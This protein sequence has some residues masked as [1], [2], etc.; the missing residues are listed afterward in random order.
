MQLVIK[1]E[2][3]MENFVRLE[4]PYVVKLRN[5]W[6]YSYGL[7]SKDDWQ[8]YIKMPS[9]MEEWKK[10]ITFPKKNVIF[11][12]QNQTQNNETNDTTDGQQSCEPADYQR[13]LGEIDPT[14]EGDVLQWLLPKARFR[15]LHETFRLTEA[16]RSGDSLLHTFWGAATE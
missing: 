5:K 2:V 3:V 12:I 4:I 10:T 7:A 13:G 14:G 6:Y 11:E 16:E 1:G 15:P 8:I 9:K